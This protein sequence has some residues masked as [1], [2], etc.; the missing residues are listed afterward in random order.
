[1]CFIKNIFLTAISLYKYLHMINRMYFLLCLLLSCQSNPKLHNQEKQ[2]PLETSQKLKLS[3]LLKDNDNPYQASVFDHY[4]FIHSD[5]LIQPISSC[6]TSDLQ[7][8]FP[9]FNSQTLSYIINGDSSQVQQLTDGTNHLYIRKKE[10]QFE[11]LEGMLTDTKQVFQQ[12]IRLGMSKQDFLGTYFQV[13]SSLFEQIQQLTVVKNSKKGTRTNYHFE[14]NQ[15]NHITWESFDHWWGST[16]LFPL[17]LASRIQLKV[18]NTTKQHGKI[19]V[20]YHAEQ[21]T[22]S[23]KKVQQ[24][25]DQANAA[26]EKRYQKFVKELQKQQVSSEQ[27]NATAPPLFNNYLVSIYQKDQLLSFVYQLSYAHQGAAHSMHEYNSFTYD[28]RTQQRLSFDDYFQLNTEEDSLQ[29]LTL[30]N[31]A[32]DLGDMGAKSI[33]EMDFHLQ[34]HGISF[35]FD[36]YELGSYAMGMPKGQV[37]WEAISPYIRQRY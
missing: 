6:K 29:L 9:T 26:F 31:E 32:I 3:E 8:Q 14:D 35:Y 7:K 27:S 11:I 4:L 5:T 2:L 16:Q 17:T 19:E 24:L 28:L 1:M 34:E 15:L 23:N 18:T 33:Y 37:S 20:D 30:I 13:D 10:N 21:L 25:S 36:A 12:N 22:Y